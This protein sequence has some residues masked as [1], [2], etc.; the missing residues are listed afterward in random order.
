MQE[1]SPTDSIAYLKGVPPDSDPSAPRPLA[2]GDMPVLVPFAPGLLCAYLWD[3]GDRFSYVQNRHLLAARLDQGRMHAS[4][5]ENLKRQVG[6]NLQLHVQGASWMLTC[7]GNFEASLLMVDELWEK[8][9]RD[10]AGEEPVAA[11]P[12]RDI[13]CFC[14]STL[15][16]GIGQ[17]HGIVERVWE[18]GD[19]LVSRQLYTR[20][21]G[22]WSPLDPE[23]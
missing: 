1:R 16:E 8:L 11:V 5:I 18:G 6:T 23:R 4:A 2:Q 14:P 13:L 15:R 21:A 7:D 9:L 19:H 17:L 3:E 10:Q 20:R 12:A 22:R